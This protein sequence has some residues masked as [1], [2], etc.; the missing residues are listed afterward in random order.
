MQLCAQSNR[1]FKPLFD[2]YSAHNHG[3]QQ[4]SKRALS[5][6]LKSILSA[7]G[8]VPIYLIIDALDECPDIS[9]AIGVP[10][11][12]QKVLEFVKELVEL[13]LPNLHICATS[14]YEFDIKA[15]L[16]RLARF[17]VSLHDQVGQ[18]QDIAE[19][20][21]SVVYSDK[22]LVMK[23]WRQEIKELVVKTLSEKADGMYE[24]RFMFA[25]NFLTIMQVSLGCVSAVSAAKMSFTEC[26]A[27]AQQITQILRRNI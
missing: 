21:H 23:K 4:P 25:T 9:R 10:P 20:I 27:S 18:K 12:R 16:E 15:S 14:R 5:Q 11:P 17:K 6:C 1:C 3:K 22:E 13:R 7:L 24:C 8:Q 2:L 26:C 19:Y